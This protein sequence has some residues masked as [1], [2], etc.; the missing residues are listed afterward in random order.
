M[1]GNVIP[2]ERE[3]Q[4]LPILLSSIFLER[5]LLL[6]HV[7]YCRQGQSLKAESNSGEG[8]ILTASLLTCPSIY[9]FFEGEL[10][11]LE[12]PCIMAKK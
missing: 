3:R 10:I 11:R 2:G 6:S 4:V 5:S 7:S 8:E 9:I 1:Y 12:L